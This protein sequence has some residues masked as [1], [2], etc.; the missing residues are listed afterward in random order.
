[1]KKKLHLEEYFSFFIPAFA[2]T[3]RM[4]FYTFCLLKNSIN[5]LRNVIRSSNN[6]FFCY[7][8]S[9]HVYKWIK[10]L[11]VWM[12]NKALVDLLIIITPHLIN[13]HNQNQIFLNRAASEGLSQWSVHN[14][15]KAYTKKLKYCDKGQTLKLSHGIKLL[16]LVNKVITPLDFFAPSDISY[17]SRISCG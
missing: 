17:L 3:Q 8:F 6:Q 4:N 16:F 12:V 9:I 14:F 5:F 2:S 7:H 1:M 15:P 13:F 10:I 11:N